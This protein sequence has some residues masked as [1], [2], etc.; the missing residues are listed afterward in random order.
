MQK[1][2]ERIPYVARHM[3]PIG[4]LQ[5]IRHDQSPGHGI[6]VSAVRDE[7][8]DLAVDLQPLH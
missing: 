2:R 3:E 5:S 7:K 6:I 1:G 4:D 8:A